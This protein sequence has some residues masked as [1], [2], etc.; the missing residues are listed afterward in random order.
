MSLPIA[1]HPDKLTAA[2]LT[3]ALGAAGHLVDGRVET[4]ELSPLGTGQMC[5]SMRVRVTY[6]GEADAP[7]S[8][9][10]KFP[11]ADE[12]S[13]LT[14][15]LM[16][17]YEKE[18][19]FY[20]HLADELPVN[21]PKP[22]YA[23]IDV[24]TG[25]FTLVLEDRSPAV[26]GDQ[27]AGCNP[28][29]AAEAVLELANL[30]A[31]RWGINDVGEHDWLA[32]PSAEQRGLLA[33]SLPMLWEEFKRRYDGAIEATL[34]RAGDTF[35]THI[36]NYLD[37]DLI[38][39]AI[40]HTDYR[41]DNLLFLP[42]AFEGTASARPTVVDWQTVAVGCPAHDVG[43]FLGTGLTT[44]DRRSIEGDVLAAY[45]RA[46]VA[47]GVGDYSTRDLEN[48]YRRG[49]WA[50]FILLVGAAVLVERT[51]RG[52]EMFLTMLHRCAQHAIDLDADETI[53]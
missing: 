16:R 24:A 7:D 25:S 15:Q 49:A 46:L 11:S 23:D 2:W 6:E 45:H 10:A 31:P 13:R 27:I 44:G 35:F 17:S 51:E 3:D 41:L 50:G 36:G 18:V 28:E 14:A 19:R 33:A 39:T 26:Q 22:Y 32:R 8:F 37:A 43:F 21:T 38:A 29:V 53:R 30:H 1:D 48:E 12:S 20:Q 34:T 40:T 9:V 42:G 5:D 52:D 4:V 47:A